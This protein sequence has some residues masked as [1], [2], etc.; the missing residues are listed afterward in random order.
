MNEAFYISATALDA[1]QRALDTVSNNIANVNST[2]YKRVVVHFTELVTAPM[3]PA[4]GDHVDANQGSGWRGDSRL[5]Q[6][7]V[8]PISLGG[9]EAHT[10]GIDFTQGQLTATGQTFDVALGGDGFMELLGPAGEIMLWR[11][12]TLEVN[13]DG[14]LAAN[15]GMA[16]KQLIAVPANASQI[17]I[18]SDGTVTALVGN[19]ATPTRLGQI[20]LVE[21]RNTATISNYGNGLYVENDSA[22]LEAAVSGQDGAGVITQGSIETSN[23]SL[24]TEMTNMLLIQQVYSANAQALQAA[25]QLMGIANSLRRG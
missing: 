11:G 7:T 9:V 5:A 13:S 2:A 3:P 22:N 21:A 10:D 14:Y 16:L 4:N 1:H 6:T 19:T 25:D 20:G 8:A 12:G 23:V 17:T 24:N 15:N 18:A